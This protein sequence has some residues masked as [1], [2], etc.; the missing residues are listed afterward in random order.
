MKAEIFRGGLDIR[1]LRN[2]MKFS[3]GKQTGGDG[4]CKKDQGDAACQELS[5]LLCGLHFVLQETYQK[6]LFNTNSV[7]EHMFCQDQAFMHV[8]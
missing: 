2:I 4:E 5:L 1:H 8:G 7:R 6:I 3:K